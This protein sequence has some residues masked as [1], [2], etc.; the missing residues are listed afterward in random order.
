MII[1]VFYMHCFSTVMFCCCFCNC[2][3]L[4]LFLLF[5][6]NGDLLYFYMKIN[7][8][9]FSVVVLLFITS[10]IILLFTS[11]LVFEGYKMFTYVRDGGPAIIAI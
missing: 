9:N 4:L 2:L 10:I 7:F 3:L 5:F 1:N 8:S 6:Y 11:L